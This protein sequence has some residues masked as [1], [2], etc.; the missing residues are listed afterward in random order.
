ME[1]RCRVTRILEQ[2]FYIY[3]ARKPGALDGF[4]ALGC[5]P[6]TPGRP[7]SPG[8]LPTE[9]IVGSAVI[10]KVTRRKDGMFQWHLA[11]VERAKRYRKPRGMPQP[12]WF[13]SFPRK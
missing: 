11:H 12:V 2:R 9:V 1:Y 13:H 5:K 4:A 8:S 6:G 7:G 3:A 10:E